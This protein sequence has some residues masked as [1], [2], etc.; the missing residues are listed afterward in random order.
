LS[1]RIQRL[2][3]KNY[4]LAETS[5]LHFK[6]EST[7]KGS[8]NYVRMFYRAMNIFVKRHYG[9]GKAGIFS[10][11]IHMAIWFRAV[12]SAI[13]K[14]VRWIGLPFIDIL[15][16]LLSFWIMKNVWSDYVRTDTQY[17][18]KLLLISFPAFSVAYLAV[19]YYAGLYDKWYRRAGLIRSTFIATLVLLA[20]YS[21]LPENLRFSRAIVLFGAVLAF[22]LISIERWLLVITGVLYKEEENNLHTLIVGS[23]DEY[24]ATKKLM[25]HAGFH[26]KILGRVAVNENETGTIGYWNRLRDIKLV[27]DFRELIFCEGSL[28]FKDIIGVVHG[29]PKNLRVKF[30]A[31]KSRSIVGSDSRDT[32]GEALSKENG[33]KISDPYNRRIK[34]LID[35]TGSLLFLVTFPFHLFLVKRP[36]EFFKNCFLV[37]FGKRT[38]IGYAGKGGPL[39]KLRQ[40]VMGCNGV[41]TNFINELPAEGLQIVNQWYARDYEPSLDLKLLWKNYRQLGS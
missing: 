19:A 41:P 37:L 15:L 3:Y 12:M 17:P 4:Y 36:I 34:R 39:P 30:H 20:A 35:I 1:Y 6:G 16:I 24:Q 2:G 5:I 21:L 11:F 32:S 13:G 38:W 8:L 9:G 26:D 7:R 23:E 31:S 33:Y 25:K 18:N 40:A 28:S 22:I 29:L 10:F 14:F 27:V